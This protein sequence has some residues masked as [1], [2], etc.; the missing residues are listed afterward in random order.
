MYDLTTSDKNP[1]T[2]FEY[3]NALKIISLDRKL[4]AI[5]DNLQTK[6]KRQKQ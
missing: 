2:N 6:F 1:N 5:I 3:N 4:D